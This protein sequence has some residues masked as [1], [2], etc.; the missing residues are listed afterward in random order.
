METE[1]L[2]WV[3]VRDDGLVL[4]VDRRVYEDEATFR[5]C[6]LFTSRCYLLLER[7]S[8]DHL[9]VRFRKKQA[10]ADLTVLIGEFANELLNQQ[11]RTVLAR[12]T[13]A[14]REQIVKRAF[15]DAVFDDAT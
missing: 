7:R 5:A 4:H 9:S 10:A 2:D 12:Q 6:Y 11:L 3:D 13:R 15:A 8:S 1:G 14:I